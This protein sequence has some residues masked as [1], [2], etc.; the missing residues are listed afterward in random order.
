MLKGLMV[1]RV[2]FDAYSQSDMSIVDLTTK[3]NIKWQMFTEI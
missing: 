3:L 2:M 1:E